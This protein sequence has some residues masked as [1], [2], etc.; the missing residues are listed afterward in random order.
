MITYEEFQKR[1]VEDI[2]THYEKVGTPVSVETSK[3][4]KNNGIT[5]KEELP[6]E[7]GATIDEVNFLILRK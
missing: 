2:T 7:M 4:H 6:K 5:L 1:V 3:V